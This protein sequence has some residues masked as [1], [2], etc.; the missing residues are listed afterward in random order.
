MRASCKSTNH[1]ISFPSV[2]N[3]YHVLSS[4]KELKKNQINSDGL[5][6]KFDSKNKLRNLDFNYLN[7]KKIFENINLA[8]KKNSKIGIVGESG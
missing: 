1:V 8:I 7:K 6:I 2:K 5:K 3:V 4:S